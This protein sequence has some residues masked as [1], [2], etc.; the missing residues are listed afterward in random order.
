[1]RIPEYGLQPGAPAH[2][3][4][5]NGAPCSGGGCRASTGAIGVPGRQVDCPKWRIAMKLLN[6]RMQIV[7]WP[8][9][10]FLRKR[11]PEVW[12]VDCHVDGVQAVKCHPG[13]DAMC[14]LDE[15]LD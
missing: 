3:I 2:F 15:R 13:R 4:A 11:Y 12:Q 9:H 1:M 6:D 8:E 14:L 10:D 5:L 7:P